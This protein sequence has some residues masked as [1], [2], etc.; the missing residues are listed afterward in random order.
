MICPDEY[1]RQRTIRLP[2][3][4]GLVLLFLV[5][6][7]DVAD[8]AGDSHGTIYFVIAVDTEPYR[9]N[10]WQYSQTL[11]PACL[12]PDTDISP[13]AV[14]ME[15]RWRDKYR[16]SSGDRL[17]V[18]WFI[19]SHEL[20]RY[21]DN[22]GC[23]AIYDAMMKY[24]DRLEEF[25]DE[26]GWHYHHAD[27]YDAD[28]DGK[29]AWSQITTFD[30]TAY[31]HGTDREIAENMLNC[32][33]TER[34]FFPAVFR[35]GWT[36]ENKDLSRWLDEI[37]PYDFSAYPPN[38]GTDKRNDPIRNRYDWT[39]APRGYS[40]YHPGRDDY[41]K[42][43]DL[44]RWIFRTVSPNNEHEWKRII[45]AAQEQGNQIL[46]YTTHS[47]DNLTIDIDRFLPTLLGLCRSS[48]VKV[49]FA[50]AA[51]AGAGISETSALADPTITISPQGDSLTITAQGVVYQNIPYCVLRNPD[52]SS[53]RIFPS[54]AGLN[55]WVFS[56]YRAEEGK[57]VCAVTGL[58][59]VTAV[60]VFG[61]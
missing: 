49:R 7:A 42:P 13:V 24:K 38:R 48:G 33:L 41:Q 1:G 15:E 32:L 17:K 14:V 27:W 53:R 56:P 18:T 26:L 20:F 22:G 28:G 16:D 35:S 3:L 39:K 45:R 51:E 46:C 54:H 11:N 19:M 52:G 10:P 21:A 60:T 57:V 34:G 2:T 43:G 8:P 44:K 36:W 37:F 29:S 6:A 9:P 30:G 59:G 31:T 23:T 50:T 55:R 58:N 12:A 40:G 47:F 5:A 4:W 61:Q 25:G